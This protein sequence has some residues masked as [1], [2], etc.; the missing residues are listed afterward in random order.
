MLS[1]DECVRSNFK[2]RAGPADNNGQLRRPSRSP[3]SQR[4][5]SADV[6]CLKKY[7]ERRVEERRHTEIGDT[8]KLDTS[9][10][11]PLPKNVPRGAQQGGAIKR[12]SRDERHESVDESAAGAEKWPTRSPPSTESR[13]SR[14]APEV[15]VGRPQHAVRSHSTDVTALK[16]PEKSITEQRRHTDCSDPRTIATRWLPQINGAKFH[17]E[18]SPLARI[19]CEITKSATS[20]WMTFAKSPSPDPVSRINPER[21]DSM[22]EHDKRNRDS[23]KDLSRDADASKWQPPRK[24]SPAKSEKGRLQRQ[25]ELDIG[26]DRSSSF[27]DTNERPKDRSLSYIDTNERAKDRSLSYIDTSERANKLSERIRDL[28]DFKTENEWPKRAGTSR[29]NTWISKSSS[30]E[31][32]PINYKPIRR[33]SQ[34]LEFNDRIDIFKSKAPQEEEVEPPRRPKRSTHNASEVF[35]DEYDE[36]LRRFNEKLRYSTYNEDLS[37][38]RARGRERRTY[39]DDYDEKVRRESRSSRQPELVTFKRD[40]PEAPAIRRLVDKENKRNSD[41]SMRPRD[42]QVSYVEID[43]TKKNSRTSDASYASVNLGKRGSVECR[44]AR[45]I[46]DVPPRRAFSQSDERPATPVPPIEFNDERYVPKKLSEPSES[47]RYK[48]YLT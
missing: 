41:V 26:R 3:R 17:R 27:V 35:A 45:Q 37:A 29:D 33:N 19:G 6:D 11:A 30:E 48:V 14:I 44:S 43:F 25:D 38:A 20:R 47:T 7:T 32:R 10:W 23:R 42:S 15:V 39:S 28:Y 34:D 8:S 1:L 46:L 18:T 24:F 12:L 31:E 5:R 40:R 16:R 36:R 4:S 21:M 2:E 22:M 9:K 13:T